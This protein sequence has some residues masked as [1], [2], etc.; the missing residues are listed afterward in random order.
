MFPD[1]FQLRTLPPEPMMAT[2][3][4]RSDANFASTA[5]VDLAKWIVK[6]NYQIKELINASNEGV[7]I[8]NIKNTYW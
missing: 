4:F 7:S 3:T 2:M 8:A 1:T 5:C 6:N